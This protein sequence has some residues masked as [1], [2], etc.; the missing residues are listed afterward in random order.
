L[1]FSVGAYFLFSGAFVISKLW[2]WHAVPLGLPALGWKTC[3]AFVVGVG[4]LRNK[5]P[6]TTD[7]KRD[8]ATK[9]MQAI[10]V[11]ALPWLGLL[12][13]WWLT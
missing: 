13:G 6:N 8:T 9:V 11:A 1:A 10:L 7:D 4:L 2:L 5:F 12:I 3:A